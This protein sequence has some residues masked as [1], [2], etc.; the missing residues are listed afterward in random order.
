VLGWQVVMRGSAVFVVA[1]AWGALSARRAH[2]YEDQ[3]TVAVGLGYAQSVGREAVQH[4]VLLDVA[5]STGLSAQWA[6]RGRLSYAL[7]PGEDALHVGIGAAELLYVVDVLELVPYAG[8]GAGALLRAQRSELEGAPAAHVVAGIDYLLSRN[9]TLELD[10]RGHLL[11]TELSTH[12]VY[13][14][15]TVSVIWMLDP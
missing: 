14:A 12:P 9:W 2:A 5:A 8:L 1:L 15:A 4:G 7:H 13:W 10:A 6:L 3:Q 11:L